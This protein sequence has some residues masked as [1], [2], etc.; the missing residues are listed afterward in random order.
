M[1]PTKKQRKQSFL[2]YALG[3]ML[4]CLIGVTIWNSF[5]G[6]PHR[7]LVAEIE[8]L[9]TTKSIASAEER[10]GHPIIRPANATGAS[11][12]L[13]AYYTKDHPA[14]AKDTITI[15]YQK[16]RQRVVEFTQRPTGGN[17]LEALRQSRTVEDVDL[18]GTPAILVSYHRP[19][20]VCEPPNEVY[21]GICQI[22]RKLVF[23]LDDTLF[24]FAADGNNITDGEL[25]VMAQ[26]L[27]DNTPTKNPAQ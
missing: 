14:I 8:G 15:I 16:N 27:I 9:Q 10:I 26:S 11:I 22:S 4:L 19:H 18:A 12:E 7:E 24:S 23:E 3:L 17:G 25:I 1:E 5:D 6:V 21:I 20:P 13:I 2:F